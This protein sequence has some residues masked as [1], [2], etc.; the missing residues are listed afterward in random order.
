MIS[1]V[2]YQRYYLVEDIDMQRAKISAVLLYSVILSL[3]IIWLVAFGFFLRRIDPKYIPSFFDMTTGSQYTINCFRSGDDL[4]KSYIFIQNKRHWT[5]IRGEV[6]AW[7]RT[8]WRTWVE[9]KPPWFTAQFIA[10]VPNE[11][12][13]VEVDPLRRR[14][15]ILGGIM[16]FAGGGTDGYDRAGKVGRGS[17]NKVGGKKS[18]SKVG[19]EPLEVSEGR[20]GVEI[21]Y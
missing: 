6:M 1:A 7:T 17:V 16:G 15:S 19:D 12:I 9:L 20:G 11:F 14:S 10:T 4:A 5:S 3:A 18:S 8:N 2:L 13:P 21:I